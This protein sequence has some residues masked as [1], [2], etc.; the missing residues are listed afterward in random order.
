M[1]LKKEKTIINT[2]QQHNII[3][4]TYMIRVGIK[5]YVSSITA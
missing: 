3:I 4:S 1:R 5:H 2:G